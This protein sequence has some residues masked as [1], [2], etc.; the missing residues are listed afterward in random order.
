MRAELRDETLR[1][2]DLTARRRKLEERRDILK[3]GLVKAAVQY[4]YFDDPEKRMPT[5]SD[6]AKN[7]GIALTGE[8]LRRCVCSAFEEQL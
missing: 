1:L 7:L 3:G 5:W 4:R 8:E 2:A 6:T